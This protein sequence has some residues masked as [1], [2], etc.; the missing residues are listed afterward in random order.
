MLYVDMVFIYSLVVSSR[1]VLFFTI[2]ELFALW[3]LLFTCPSTS[4]FLQLFLLFSKAPSLLSFDLE[5][6]SS[7]SWSLQDLAQHLTA[8]ADDSHAPPVSAFP[9]AHLSFKRICGMSSLDKVLHFALSKT[10]YSTFCAGPHQF[11]RVSF[12][13]TYSPGK[14]LNALPPLYSPNIR[15]IRLSWA[16]FS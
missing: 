12:Q 5:E 4:R 9:K 7:W 13:W 15:T 11:L 16:R 10:T 14:I 8:W 6:C 2:S 3:S 1:A